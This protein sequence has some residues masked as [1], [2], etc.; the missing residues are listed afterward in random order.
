MAAEF[1][2][3]VRNS[4]RA[5]QAAVE[6]V[7]RAQKKTTDEVARFGAEAAK[8]YKAPA[9]VLPKTEEA[10]KKNAKAWREVGAAM[11]RIGGPMG[12]IVARFGGGFGMEG[13]L[14]RIAAAA[15]I[16]GL[17]L[18]AFHAVVQKQANDARAAAEAYRKMGDAIRGAQDKARAGAGAGMTQAGDRRRLTAAGPEAIEQAALIGNLSIADGADV[19]QGVAAIYGKFGAG[20]RSRGTVDAARELATTGAF[21][22]SEASAALLGQGADMSAPGVGHSVAA[23]LYAERT[24]RRGGNQVADFDAVLSRTQND[25]WLRKSEGVQRIRETLRTEA[26]DSVG[27]GEAEAQARGELAA[28]RDPTTAAVLQVYNAHVREIEILERIAAA[29]S[30][31]AAWTANLG[32]PFGGEGSE[33]QKARRPAIAFDVGIRGIDFAP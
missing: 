26:R 6:G 33:T 3:E 25:A 1:E 11:A 4:M 30:T 23:R 29:Q 18:K 28:S 20:G 12:E 2:A 19:D 22:F 21:S 5:L 16:A 9:Q 7:G 27:S 15:A 8:A 32:L 10:L 31:I 24:G 13:G 17:A 14:S